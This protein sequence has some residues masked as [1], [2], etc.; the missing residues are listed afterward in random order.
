LQLCSG[1]FRK[2]VAESMGATGVIMAEYRAKLD[3]LSGR[4]GLSL[5]ASKLMFHA[6]IRQRMAPLM[7]QIMYEFERSVLSKDQMAQKSGK[8]MGDDV[9]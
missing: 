9:M 4:L 2:A 7:Q 1:T 3:E 8:D 5:E 6:A